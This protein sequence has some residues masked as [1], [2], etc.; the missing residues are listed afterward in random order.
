MPSPAP[1]PHPKHRLSRTPADLCVTASGTP[2]DQEVH[3]LL[4]SI[5]KKRAAFEAALD[6]KLKNSTIKGERGEG[7]HQRVLRR[8]AGSGSACARENSLRA[9]RPAVRCCRFYSSPRGSTRGHPRNQPG[10]EDQ[11]VGRARDDFRRLSA[12]YNSG[13]PRPGTKSLGSQARRL[14]D[15][16]S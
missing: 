3:A 1:S 13:P 8:L 6:E 15:A 5:E 2:K 16:E 10:S 4:G 7:Q 12:A 14:N 11:G 9:T